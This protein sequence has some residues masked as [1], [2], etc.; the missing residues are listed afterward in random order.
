[1]SPLRIL[2]TGG[3]GYIG[4]HAVREILERGH[5]VVVLDDLSKGHREALPNHTQLVVGRTQD[6]ELVARI[7][8]EQKIDAVIHFA[9]SIEV[10]E[11]VREPLKYFE[12]N[13]GGSISLLRAMQDTKT[14]T[15]V[16]SST[17]AVYGNPDS[18]PISESQPPRP[19]NPYGRSKW[20]V[21]MAI[22]DCAR[23]WGL[24]ATILRYFNVAGAHPS[25]EIGE[26]HEPESHLIPNVLLS[27]LRT[28]HDIKIFGTD[29]P[30]KDGTCIRDYIH[31]VDLARAHILAVE[32]PPDDGVAIFNLGSEAGF[33][34]R[35]V[36]GACRRVTGR[37]IKVDEDKR[38]LGDPPSLV[39]S[40]SKIRKALGWQRSFPHLDEIVQTAWNWHCRHEISRKLIDPLAEL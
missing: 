9:G 4:C 36:I 21:E 7:I 23:A 39:A 12:N 10:S 2:V 19:I 32:Q 37:P 8:A 1:M 24:Q 40:S 25:G 11:S 33:S 29:Y 15:L 18:T 3:A 38:R 27:A 5:R 28:G 6:T 26:D 22:E 35:E 30:T 13:F 31:V 14:R 17:A 20:M 34:V 16:F